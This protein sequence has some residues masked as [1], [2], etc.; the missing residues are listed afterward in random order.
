MLGLKFPMLKK[1]NPE[2][3]VHIPVLAMRPFSYPLNIQRRLKNGVS[4]SGDKLY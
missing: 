3:N 2:F 1:V 4:D